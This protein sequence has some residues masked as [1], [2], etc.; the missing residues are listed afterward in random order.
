M[1]K[2][3][4]L[5]LIFLSCDGGEKVGTS[6]TPGTSVNPGAGGGT[7]EEDKYGT[8]TCYGNIEDGVS[9]SSSRQNDLFKY[10]VEMAGNHN[11]MIGDYPKAIEGETITSISDRYNSASFREGIFEAISAL[12]NDGAV[13]I[14]IKAKTQN[15]PINNEQGCYGRTT[16]GGG[17]LQPYTKVGIDIY[18]YAVEVQRDPNNLSNIT[19]V[20]RIGEPL[21]VATIDPISPEKCSPLIKI[22]NFPANAS[23]PDKRIV[24]LFELRRSVSD[25]K[26]LTCQA[27]GVDCP[28]NNNQTFGMNDFC[29][30]Y[31]VRKNECV[32]MTLQMATNKT[33]FFRGYSRF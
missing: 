11:F 6:L 2:I 19:S 28:E 17:Y 23:S 12:E 18:R 25:S 21:K 32:R 29:P 3:I 14:R 26:C 15:K 24:T 8:K 22:N 20:K 33:K 31:P 5:A 30:Y 7:S 4:F 27:Q 10:D 16:T 1:F 13:Y 9:D